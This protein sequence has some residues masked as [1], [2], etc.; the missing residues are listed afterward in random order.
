LWPPSRWWDH[1]FRKLFS[2]RCCCCCSR[3]FFQE[4]SEG[5][6]LIITQARNLPTFRSKS[7]SKV[8]EW[9]RTERLKLIGQTIERI[10]VTMLLLLLL[11]PPLYM[12]ISFFSLT[13]FSI[14]TSSTT[15]RP[16]F[17]L[18]LSLSFVFLVFQFFLSISVF[19]FYHLSL[20]LFFSLSVCLSVSLSHWHSVIL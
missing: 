15:R 6:F 13:F 1:D 4:C 16:T 9:M 7:L 8:T 3:L 2:W 14:C 17:N 11:L 19:H 5:I 18:S 20:S 10:E 12:E